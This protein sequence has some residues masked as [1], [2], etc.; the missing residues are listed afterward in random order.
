M[1]ILSSFE[2]KEERRLL[3]IINQKKVK[4]SPLFSDFWPISDIFGLILAQN[5]ISGV[6]GQSFAPD[7]FKISVGILNQISGEIRNFG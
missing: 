1:K 6:F 5:E 2:S 7:G 3:R 4:K